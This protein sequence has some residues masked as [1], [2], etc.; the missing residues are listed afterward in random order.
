ML[1]SIAGYYSNSHD[2]GAMSSSCNAK[3]HEHLCAMLSMSLLSSLD[4][5]MQLK[6]TEKL[7][8]RTYIIYAVRMLSPLTHVLLGPRFA[9]DMW[10]SK[11][12]DDTWM[13]QDFIQS[14]S[15]GYKVQRALAQG[16]QF[17][18][19]IFLVAGEPRVRLVRGR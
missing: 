12:L 9:C 14:S 17:S 1:E 3:Q 4:L 13:W 10:H 2:T 19:S 18:A 8:K 5:S 7:V 16:D 6:N 11:Y 15:Y